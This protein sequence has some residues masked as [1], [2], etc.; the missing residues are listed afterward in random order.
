MNTQGSFDGY[1]ASVTRGAIGSPDPVA[2]LTTYYAVNARGE[3]TRLTDPENNHYVTEYNPLGQVVRRVEPSVSTHGGP[4][5]NYETHYVYDGAGRRVMVRRLNIDVDGSPLP[6]T[7]VD[8]SYTYDAIGNRLTRRVE[9]DSTSGNDLTTEYAYDGNSQLIA[10]QKPRGNRVFYTYDERRLPLRHFYGI[11][12]GVSILDGYPADHEYSLTGPLYVGSSQCN[13]DGP[14]NPVGVVDA[15]GNITH[16]VYDGFNRC[17]AVSDPNG[18]GITYEYDDASNRLTAR[19]GMVSSTGVL[20]AHMATQYYRYDDLNRLYQKVYDIDPPSDESLLVDPHVDPG[21]SVRYS[22]DGMGRLVDVTD[23]EGRTT[24]YEYDS[25]DRRVRRTDPVGNVQ[26]YTYDDNS[27]RIRKVDTDQPGASQYHTTYEYDSLNR[28]RA[29]HQR[30]LNGTSVDHVYRYDYD[31]RHNRR[32]VGDPGGNF[33]GYSYDD[34]NRLVRR[35]CYNGDPLGT[36]ADETERHEYTY[37]VNSRVISYRTYTD[38]SLYPL[39][40]QNTR[41]TYD[42]L[43]RLSRVAYPD[44]DDDVITGDDGLDMIYDRIEYEYDGNSNLTYIR[45]QREVEHLRFYDAGNRLDEELFVLPLMVS[46]VDQCDYEYD[47]L[48]RLIGASNNYADVFMQYDSLSRV[49]LE[50]QSIR[51]DGNGFVAGW[52]YPV[53]VRNDYDRVSNRITCSVDDG[54]PVPSLHTMYVYDDLN[55]IGTVQA[56]YYGVPLHPVADYNYVGAWR[57]DSAMLGNGA[58]LSCSYDDKRRVAD[59]VWEDP[60]GSLLVGS[61]YGYDDVDNVVF[62]RILHDQLLYD[63]MAYNDRYE[64]VAAEYR[65]PTDTIAAP[66]AVFDYDD[67]HNRVTSQYQDPFASAPPTADVYTTNQAN[68]YEIIDRDS[69]PRLQAYDPAGNA[70]LHVLWPVGTPGDTDCTMTWDA[71]NRMHGFSAPATVLPD[72][73]YRYDPLGR[74]VATITG[75][76]PVPDRRF[77]YDGWT[78][79]E[80]RLFDPGATLSNAP[81]KSERVYVEG[82]NLDHHILCAIDGDGDGLLAGPTKNVPV[83][84]ADQE[85]Y[86]LTNDKNSTMAILD[87]DFGE[88][89]L[90]YYRY[91]VTGEPTVLPINVIN[92][93]DP[94]ET[95]M[96]PLD[97]SDNAPMAGRSSEA[98]GNPYLYTGRRWDDA[99]GLYHYRNRQYDPRSGAFLSRDPAGYN[100]FANLYCYVGNRYATFTDPLGLGPEDDDNEPIDLTEVDEAPPETPG[101]V[102]YVASNTPFQKICGDE[103]G[104]VIVSDDPDGEEEGEPEVIVEDGPDPSDE[105]AKPKE[106][107]KEPDKE[108][109]KEKEKEKAT[110][111]KKFIEFPPVKGEAADDP[112]GGWIDMPGWHQS[113]HGPREVL[114]PPEPEADEDDE[115]G[116]GGWI[117]RWKR[118]FLPPKPAPRPPPKPAGGISEGIDEEILKWVRE[119]FVFSGYHPIAGPG[120]YIYP[121]NQDPSPTDRPTKSGGASGSSGSGGQRGR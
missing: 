109:K 15:L 92:P 71:R 70:G 3:V 16:F 2:E 99:T 121:R 1:L 45:D 116:F 96:T 93:L 78:V 66:H 30:G 81:S 60:V 110:G 56:E 4:D 7:Y 89:V 85:Y 38:V 11:D 54:S 27:N 102:P 90:E 74:R 104:P 97:L 24:T 37:D 13:Y 22:Y 107:K 118:R 51:L 75:S 21:A 106:E 55:R 119:N 103:S 34:L 31:S 10:A 61:S 108:K 12:P 80:E 86:L 53:E 18:N 120:F 50:Q 68:E 43:D 79:V 41:Y 105:K 87:A 58:T 113:L 47:P 8:H 33:I 26:E 46:G 49:T 14:G 9:T 100:H 64:V 65:A 95:E 83:P 69:V 48:N 111:P 63:N 72:R 114:P 42:S 91:T 25:A 5:V 52:Q 29:V 76:P 20:G 67:V 82:D 77:I 98:F 112:G 6:N 28:L 62:E 115:G 73:Q 40:E 101:L 19:W 35:Q 36:R 117:R 94:F 17:T 23:P 88:R 84:G 44:S 39:T 59:R 57:L 32:L